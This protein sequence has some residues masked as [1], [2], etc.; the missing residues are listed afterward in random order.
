MII[1]RNEV[2]RL[3]EEIPLLQ[4]KGLRLQRERNALVR[5]SGPAGYGACSLERGG[6]GRGSMDALTL[7]ER[8]AGLNQKIKECLAAL[9]AIKQAL[10]LLP[11]KNGRLLYLRYAKRLTVEEVA[12]KIGRS[13]RQTYR[14]LNQA[15]ARLRV[16]LA[17]SPAGRE[18]MREK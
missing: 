15:H 14:L 8:L 2:T 18:L 9:Q 10:A 3:L 11:P 6:S 5:C 13:Q 16:H 4:E 12:E 1:L 17:A 7:C